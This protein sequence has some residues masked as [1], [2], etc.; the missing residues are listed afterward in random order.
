[1]K[2]LYKYVVISMDVERWQTSGQRLCRKIDALETFI[3]AHLTEGF[4]I[5]FCPSSTTSTGISSYTTGLIWL[6][7]HRNNPWY[8]PFQSHINQGIPYKYLTAI[9][10]ERKDLLVWN[11]KDWSLDTWFV[12]SCSEHV[13]NHINPDSVVKI[14]PIL[15]V[16]FISHTC[17][18]PYAVKIALGVSCFCIELYR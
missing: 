5:P 9:L 7:F 11:H 10:T 6:N 3:L 15:G 2:L 4:I 13:P 1:M 17:Q 12:V 14:G 16:H 18:T 8:V